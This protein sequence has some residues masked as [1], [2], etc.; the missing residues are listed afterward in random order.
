MSHGSAVEP[1]NFGPFSHSYFKFR[2]HVQQSGL[3]LFED[4]AVECNRPAQTDSKSE[5]RAI[6]NSY[7]FVSSLCIVN[8]TLVGSLAS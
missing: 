4:K 5:S 7:S 8:A 2:H 6:R 1:F 3:L